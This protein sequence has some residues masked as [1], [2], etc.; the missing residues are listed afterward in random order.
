MCIIDRLLHIFIVAC[1]ILQPD[2]FVELPKY[3]TSLKLTKIIY[4][5]YSYG[6]HC[7]VGY[8]YKS[9]RTLTQPGGPQIRLKPQWRAS[10]IFGQIQNYYPTYIHKF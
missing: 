5:Y 1:F 8:S 7:F 2:N 4:Y 10:N 3:D 6:E 9:T